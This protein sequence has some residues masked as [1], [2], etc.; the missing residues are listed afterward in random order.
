MQQNA[1]DTD[2]SWDPDF[3]PDVGEHFF[4]HAAILHGDKVI[5]EAT[6]SLTRVYGRPKLANPKQLVSLRLDAVVLEKL[7]ASGPGWQSRANQMLRK[8][9]GV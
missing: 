1:P 9:V 3:I 7:R 4:K 5:R 2:E 6:G 8:A